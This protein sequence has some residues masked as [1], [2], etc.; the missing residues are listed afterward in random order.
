MSALSQIVAF[1]FHY[2]HEVRTMSESKQFVNNM[3]LFEHFWQ[4]SQFYE[5][6][7]DKYQPDLTCNF[8]PV[9][10]MLSTSRSHNVLQN[11]QLLDST[12]IVE[13]EE[14]VAWAK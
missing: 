10:S 13:V 4:F 8:L 7:N 11:L 9:P 14:K 5:P 1:L 12:D 3:H 2:L 6:N